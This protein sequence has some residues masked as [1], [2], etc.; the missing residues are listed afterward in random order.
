MEIQIKLESL[1]SREDIEAL[2]GVIQSRM[3]QANRFK[4]NM[5]EVT[6]INLARFNSLIKLYVKMKRNNKDISFINCRSPK[7]LDLISKTQFSNV[8]K[9]E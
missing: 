7:I 2:D 1:D 4:V 6:S 9:S 8:F 3:A 5:E